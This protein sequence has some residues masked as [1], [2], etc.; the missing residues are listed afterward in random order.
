LEHQKGSVILSGKDAER[1]AQQLLPTVNRF[2]GSKAE[3]QRAVG[4]LETAGSAAAALT[5]V[6]RTL[7]AKDSDKKWKR[8]SSHFGEVVEKL[9]GVLHGMPTHERLALEMA[10]HEESE[11]RAMEGELAELEAAWREAEEIAHIADTMFVTPAVEESVDRLK[12]ARA[13]GA[14]PTREPE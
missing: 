8:K 10:L 1:A 5:R 9:P 4:V 11:R 2:G 7:G 13:L 12:R 3:V 14:P 6:Q